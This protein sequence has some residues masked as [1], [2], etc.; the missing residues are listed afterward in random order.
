M[1]VLL[2]DDAS[3]SER[4]YTISIAISIFNSEQSNGETIYRYRMYVE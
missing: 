3:Q 1:M 2:A 4:H